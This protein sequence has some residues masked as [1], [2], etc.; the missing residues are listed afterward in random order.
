MLNLNVLTMAGRCL[1]RRPWAAADS[2]FNSRR[3]WQVRGAA[4]ASELQSR[5]RREARCDPPSDSSFCSPLHPVRQSITRLRVSGQK[6]R[7]SFSHL[8]SLIKSSDFFFLVSDMHCD[9]STAIC[10]CSYRPTC[11]ICLFLLQPESQETPA[12]CAC[13]CCTVVPFP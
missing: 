4:A 9:R 12:S 13:A 5:R 10:N 11:F 3:W 1:T 7:T 8:M 2:L 6:R